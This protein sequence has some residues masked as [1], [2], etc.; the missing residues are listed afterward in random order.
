MFQGTGIGLSL[1]KVY[2]PLVY[3]VF[4]VSTQNGAA[5]RESAWR[6][7]FCEVTALTNQYRTSRQ[8]VHGNIPARKRP[9]AR[10][11]MHR[12]DHFDQKAKLCQRIGSRGC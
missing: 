6:K 8:R 12:V 11:Q 2:N 9:F 3:S 4:S 1:T 5:I 7:H 10:R